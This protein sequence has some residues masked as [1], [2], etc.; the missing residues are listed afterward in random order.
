VAEFRN[1]LA[2]LA[3]RGTRVGPEALIERI[4]LEMA[5]DPIVGAEIRP[6]AKPGERVQST[7]S[8]RRGLGI[9]LAV[10]LAVLVVGGAWLVISRDAPI[11][12]PTMTSTLAVAESFMEAW[13]AGDGE[14]VAAMVSAEATLGGLELLPPSHDWYRAVGQEFQTKGCEVLPITF[15]TF[16]GVSCEYTFEN[17]LT[18]ALGMEP[19]G[20]SFLLY[21]SGSGIER[22]DGNYEGAATFVHHDVSSID[23][24]LAEWVLI[25]HPDDFERMFG[26]AFLSPVSDPTSIALWEQYTDELTASPEATARF[27]MEE[28]TRWVA[29]ED[30]FNHQVRPICEAATLRLEA[31]VVE[32][33][34]LDQWETIT[35][36]EDLAAMSETVARISEE[37]LA[38]MRALPL[39]PEAT[40]S[41]LS[42]FY[43]LAEQRIDVLR[44]AA[45]AASAGATA[46][47]EMLS[48]EELVL[49]G[50]AD[51]LLGGCPVGVWQ[52]H[53]G[54]P[55][56]D[57]IAPG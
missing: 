56:W 19:V 47:V 55:L 4:E 17:K 11:A 27:V 24:T 36:L 50:Q 5:D 23:R 22:A 10:M 9:G 35:T 7:R 43:S 12:E 15:R 3:E 33:L 48:A 20:G 2:R 30:Y 34:G 1:E 54:Q 13:A 29:R 42:V 21:L 31:T 49:R 53:M 57:S 25:N 40:R 32:D 28:E 37:T 52:V 45:A 6:K 39:P 26:D 44:Q 51:W 14:A 38:E 18:R 8:L 41:W 16:Q 46:R